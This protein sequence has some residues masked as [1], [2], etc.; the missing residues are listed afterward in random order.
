MWSTLYCSS[1]LND[2][3][4]YIILHMI[5]TQTVYN[6]ASY[7]GSR[8]GGSGKESLIHTV[9]ACVKFCTRLARAIT[10]YDIL[11]TFDRMLTSALAIFASTASIH[12]SVLSDS[13]SCI[14]N[15]Y[16]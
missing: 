6:L 3:K 13:T 5:L 2:C 9:C 16:K 15:G 8:K 11:V 12:P 14:R 4:G 7:P 1:D 10:C